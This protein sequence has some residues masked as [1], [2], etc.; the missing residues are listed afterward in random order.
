MNEST[1]PTA[2]LQALLGE[3][4]PLRWWQRRSLW[5]ALGALLLVAGALY[6]WQERQQADQLPSYVT[7]PLKTGRL[8]L[9]VSANGTL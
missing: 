8:A 3:D 9:N 7:T 6:F 1:T 5:L 2:E 4:A